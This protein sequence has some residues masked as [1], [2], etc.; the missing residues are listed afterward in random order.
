MEADDVM[1]Y[2]NATELSSPLVASF[3]NLGSSYD[4]FN[5][6]VLIFLQVF[7]I[8]LLLAGVLMHVIKALSFLRE[9]QY[10]ALAP[11]LHFFLIMAN[12]LLA[13]SWIDPE[14]YYGVFSIFGDGLELSYSSSCLHTVGFCLIH[15]SITRTIFKIETKKKLVVVSFVVTVFLILV[16][17]IGTIVYFVC[18]ER[19]NLNF[20]YPVLGATVV[21]ILTLSYLISA[22]YLFFKFC[23]FSSISSTNRKDINKRYTIMAICLTILGMASSLRIAVWLILSVNNS[24]SFS[25]TVTDLVIGSISEIL[26]SIGVFFIFQPIHKEE[27]PLS[28]NNSNKTSKQFQPEESNVDAFSK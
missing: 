2:M 17:V 18:Y 4:E 7:F 28:F 13:I 20:N 10:K 12:M 3:V 25:T 11:Y 1:R 26:T 14:G 9:K 8:S 21:S 27:K 19:Y 5:R 22:L 15:L 23:S 24:V 6:G 16:T